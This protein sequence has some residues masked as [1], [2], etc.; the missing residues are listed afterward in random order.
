LTRSLLQ[1]T[2]ASG[3]TVVR[4]GECVFVIDPLAA[5]PRPETVFIY[6]ELALGATYLESDPIGLL[7]GINTYAYVDDAPVDSSDPLGLVQYDK[8]NRNIG[9]IICNGSGGIAVQFPANIP[10]MAE[11][12]LGDCLRAHEISHISDIRRLG[13]GAC[14]GQARGVI[15][16]FDTSAQLL[17]SERKAYDVELACLQKKLEGMSDCDECKKW[18]QTRIKTNGTYLGL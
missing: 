16:T 9:T 3:P 17:A 13:P 5:N 6:G 10:P 14:K 8:P 4:P 7:G 18:V 15:P 2:L 11:K 12:C 1:P